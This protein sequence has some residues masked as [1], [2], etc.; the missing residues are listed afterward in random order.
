MRRPAARRRRRRRFSWSNDD[1][2]PRAGFAGTSLQKL[3]AGRKV[4]LFALPGAFTG[5]C[6]KGHV[7]S[8]A[9]LI[10]DFE[11]KGIDEV[12]CVSIN[13]PYCM[14][15]WAKTMGTSGIN[16]YA[17]ADESFTRAVSEERDCTGDALG[18]G[19]GRIARVW[20]RSG[21]RGRGLR[22]GGAG[23]IGPCPTARR[24]WRAYRRVSV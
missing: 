21:G 18:P 6:E 13:D 7:P 10:P 20:W 16:F 11:A 15:G 5:V 3:F 8:F 12:A 22:R 4:V 9:K 19:C 24:C 1:G 14:N 2:V 17:T 23:G